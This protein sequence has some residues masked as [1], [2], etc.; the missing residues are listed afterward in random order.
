MD[1]F[2]FP[3]CSVLLHSPRSIQHILPRVCRNACFLSRLRTE[4][5]LGPL[6]PPV[7][8]W[9]SPKTQGIEKM[10][11]AEG[12]AAASPRRL[13]L[14]DCV[15]GSG[16]MESAAGTPQPLWPQSRGGV[17]DNGNDGRHVSDGRNGI[18]ADVSGAVGLR[19][20]PAP[21]FCIMIPRQQPQPTGESRHGQDRHRH[22][23]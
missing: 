1:A 21:F 18:C 15:S 7:L 11:D 10:R 2:H 4:V 6:A 16:R 20:I 14:D 5:W 8:T 12:V 23:S 19:M 3:F 17:P 9:A 13:F 22:Q